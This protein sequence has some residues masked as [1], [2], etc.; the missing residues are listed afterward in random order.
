MFLAKT[1]GFPVSTRAR[2]HLLDRVLGMALDV[3]APPSCCLCRQP[4][5]AVGLL[6][7]G[8]W[9]RLH[10][11]EEP[12]C[13][14]TGLPLCAATASATAPDA[15]LF[16]EPWDSLRAVA[17][18]G[19]TARALVHRLK[20]HDHHEVLPAMARL[21][22]RAHA[23][24]IGADTLLVPV[25]LYRWRLWRRRFNQSAL[26]ARALAATCGGRYLPQALR[27]SRPTSPQVGLSGAAR[28]A[29]VHGA[30]MVPPSARAL[31]ASGHVMLVDDVF[32]TGATARACVRALRRAGARRVDVAVFALAG[33]HS[34]LHI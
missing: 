26:L 30:F 3:L 13:P 20:Y 29:N 9:A 10:L 5:R 25:P 27:R 7:A 22:A 8:C 33:R 4:V 18:H 2:R 11:V 32:T 17:L 14:A 23:A 16:R 24:R 1:A 15:A 34:A 12:C 21:M 31:V 19:E 6:C 28:R